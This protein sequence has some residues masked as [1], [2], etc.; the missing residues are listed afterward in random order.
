MSDFT[1]ELSIIYN[2]WLQTNFKFE[3]NTNQFK[4]DYSD[5]F[6]IHEYKD[7]SEIEDFFSYNTGY[8]DSMFDEEP[9]VIFKGNDEDSEAYDTYE[10][11]NPNE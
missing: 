8:D 5:E 9:V 4:E 7:Y 3:L 2:T 10:Y 6:P 1:Q 11:A